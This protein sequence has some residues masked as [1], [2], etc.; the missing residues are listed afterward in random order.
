M[1]RDLKIN[2]LRSDGWQNVSDIDNKHADEIDWRRVWG[3][4]GQGDLDAVV[5]ELWVKGS[6]G[7]ED[8]APE[9]TDVFVY[10]T[11]DDMRG[12][13]VHVWVR[14]PEPLWYWDSEGED[15]RV[16]AGPGSRGKRWEG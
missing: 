11:P 13:I 3:A 2:L 5:D 1:A 4:A 9:I 14:S 7:Y 8:G 12:E 15:V 16:D 10:S 6:I